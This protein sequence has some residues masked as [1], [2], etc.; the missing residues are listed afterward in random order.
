MK[1]IILN[2]NLEKETIDGYI[3]NPTEKYVI[4]LAEEM[5][6]QSAIMSSF[7]I[8]DIHLHLK[9]IMPGFLK[10]DLALMFQIRQMN[11]LLHIMVLNLFG[12]RNI[13]KES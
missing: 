4:N 8:M 11:L 6:F 12:K 5:E 2:Q 13:L 1:K 9:T 10:T 7:Q 3:L